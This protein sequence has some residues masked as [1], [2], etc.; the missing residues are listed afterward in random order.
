MGV[1]ADDDKSVHV[2]FRVTKVQ[3][4]H[5][6]P[7]I[8]GVLARLAQVGDLDELKGS[9]MQAAFEVLV[10]VKIAVGLFDDDL[11]LKQE[12][13]EHF[14]D[15]ECRV[16]GITSSE[17]DVLQVEEHRHRRSGI[18]GAHSFTNISPNRE[19]PPAHTLVKSQGSKWPNSAISIFIRDPKPSI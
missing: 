11:S 4:V 12:A 19:K 13:F 8:G 10:S 3:C 7:D 17:C 5:H 9:F 16:M 15:V 18:L 2:S 1:G 6:H 14:P